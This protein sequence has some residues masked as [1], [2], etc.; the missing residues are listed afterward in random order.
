V[1][2]S[3]AEALELP[4]STTILYPHT[5]KAQFPS[6]GN[7]YSSH[8][9][10]AGYGGIDLHRRIFGSHRLYLLLVTPY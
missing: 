3:S 9:W 8:V 2:Y 10:K 4:A 5:T 1:S 7:F 6:D